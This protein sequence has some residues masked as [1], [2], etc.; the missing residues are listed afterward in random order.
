[1]KKTARQDCLRKVHAN[2][3]RDIQSEKA[4]PHKSR[5]SGTRTRIF[6]PGP[7]ACGLGSQRLA[8]R[9]R[10]ERGSVAGLGDVLCAFLFHALDLI[11]SH[12]PLSHS[13]RHGQVFLL[14][15]TF[16]KFDLSLPY[17]GIT[18]VPSPTPAQTVTN[19]PRGPAPVTWRSS[20]PRIVHPQEL[21][22]VHPRRWREPERLSDWPNNGEKPHPI[23]IL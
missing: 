3:G 13:L 19:G 7:Q 14:S 22:P 1:M 5:G 10:P 4:C 15:N 6:L 23:R 18:P 20:R 16:F 8:L 9:R 12:P 2:V 11:I 17:R 21:S